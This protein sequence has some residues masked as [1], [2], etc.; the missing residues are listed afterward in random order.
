MSWREPYWFRPEDHR[1]CLRSNTE[2]GW[3][4]GVAED[5]RQVLHSG[6]NRLAFD[7]DGR[8]LGPAGPELVVREAPIRV[9]RFWLPEIWTGVEDLPAPLADYLLDPDEFVQEPS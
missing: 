2:Y 5:G 7:A 6:K 9:L 4:T 1:Y 3:T 8:L